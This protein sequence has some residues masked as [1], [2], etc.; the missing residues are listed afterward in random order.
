MGGLSRWQRGARLPQ[1]TTCH[2]QSG[3][4]EQNEVHRSFNGVRVVPGSSWIHQRIETGECSTA[5]K[6]DAASKS[7]QT[8]RNTLT[9]PPPPPARPLCS[10]H[11]QCTANEQRR[12]RGS[13]LLHQNQK[14][15][16]RP[17][18]PRL[19]LLQGLNRGTMTTAGGGKKCIILNKVA[20][21]EVICNPGGS[22]AQ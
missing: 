6:V 13:H 21:D 12:L 5:T 8:K 4:E 10:D 1:S 22:E 15:R 2:S 14:N 17:W 20:R 19:K 9:V 11:E 18:L 7:S 16:E 3:K